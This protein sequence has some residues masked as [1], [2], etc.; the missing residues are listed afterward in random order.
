MAQRVPLSVYS[1][2]L[3]RCTKLGCDEQYEV[4]V[5]YALSPFPH[6][7]PLPQVVQKVLDDQGNES[8]K[9][10]KKHV[11]SGARRAVSK[12]NLRVVHVSFLS[13]FCSDSVSLKILVAIW[14]NKS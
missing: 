13:L 4:L 1:S 3:V 11:M 10:T 5:S 9:V 14:S 7:L 2:F 8:P 6:N 12:K